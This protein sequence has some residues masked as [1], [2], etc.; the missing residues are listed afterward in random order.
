MLTNILTAIAAVDPAKPAVNILGH[1][2]TYGQLQLESDH[3]AQALAAQHLPAGSPVMLYCDQSFDTI[4]A[5]LGC[6][7]AGHAYIPVDT[8]SPNDRLVMIEEIAQPAMIIALAALP[9][10]MHTP[11]LSG[12]AW[13]AAKQFQGQQ[14]LQPVLGA[15]NFYIIFTSGTTGRPKGVQISHANLLSFVNWMQTFAW[16]QAVKALVQA[17]YSFDLSVMSLYPTLV[18]GGELEVLPARVT[19]NLK[20]LF[21]TLP[22]LGMQVWVSTPS[23]VSICLLDK[24]FDAAHY[25]ALQQFYFC[26]EELT[27]QVAQT[28]LTRFPQADVYNTYGPTEA[29]VATTAVK[30]TQAVLD[31]YP[32]LPIGVAQPDT[33]ISLQ[34]VQDGIGEL[35]LQG[36]NVSKGY[37]NNPDKTQAAFTP[38]GYATGDLGYQDGDMWFYSG[39]TDFQI[40]L[41]GYRIELE[42]VNHYLNATPVIA[43]A[44]AVPKYDAQHKVSQLIAYVVPTKDAP[45]GLALTK[46]IRQ[47]LQETMMSY[48]IPQ[49]FK[50]VDKLPLTANGKVA[51][52]QLMQVVN[53]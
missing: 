6:V 33:K 25:P 2:Y 8:H 50:Y 15:Q 1:H 42:E 46:A 10:T 12:A 29:T 13:Q 49:R 21:E 9:L 23:F 26:G 7:K 44:V 39:R 35:Y 41:N 28:L 17:P 27:H 16:P 4:V 51:I 31:Q 24:N 22:K 3:V 40:K 48:M 30:I 32:R 20:D 43:S 52:K 11:T 36:P 5:M 45:S 14:V 34:H 53:A 47:H 38:A 19:A 18:A 37:L